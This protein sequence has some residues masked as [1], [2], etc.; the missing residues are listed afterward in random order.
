M[1]AARVE[2]QQGN[3]V[4]GVLV[5]F[6]TTRGTVDPTSDISNDLGLATTNL[7]TTETATVTATSGGSATALNGTV[8]VTVP[9]LAAT[10]AG[11]R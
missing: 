2:D 10:T 5:S 9:L 8:V 6:T 1:I 4:P 3:P 7:S 11:T